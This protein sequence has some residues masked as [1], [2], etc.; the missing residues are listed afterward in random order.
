MRSK[1]L[2]IVSSLLAG[3]MIVMALAGCTV[4]DETPVEDDTSVQEE[5]PVVEDTP[6]TITFTDG[7]D[8]EVTVTKP[9]DTVVS[10]ISMISELMVALGEK[11]HIIA[12][13]R[14]TATSAFIFYDLLSLPDIT[15]SE[16]N[17][18]AVDYEAII[19]LDPDVFITGVVP[20][21]GF[22]DIV[23]ALE[24]EI[25][26]I[27]LSYDTPDEIV[28]SVELLGELFDCQEAA[29]EYIEFFQGTIDMIAE[30]T[31][32]IPEED[33]PVVYYEWLPYY[34][35][36]KDLY[37]YQNQIDLAGGV[38]AAADMA[39]TYGTIDPEWVIE[40]DPDII[41]SMT[42]D[43][44]YMGYDAVE[45]GY[46]VDDYS[47]MIAYRDSILNRSELSGVT[48]IKEGRVYV[49]HY[50]LSALSCIG[51]AYMAKWLHPDLFEDLDPQALH[52]EWLTRFM[53]ID[54]DLDEHGVFVYPQE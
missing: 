37:I 9:V 44:T 48:A 6:E 4:Q 36:N 47:S 19:E 11:D 49:F 28:A 52:Q 13:D 1:A 35:F 21:D 46:E 42:M 51:Y 10:G 25:P 41:L 8:H 30:R 20:Q 22:D 24:P 2:K 45:C 14:S 23:A 26:V 40:Q 18:Y 29:D 32:D 53:G 38:N 31:A 43:Y 5:T 27:A 16:D 39:T 3:L 15:T 34:T 50:N 17:H 33:K 12:I 7:F 54:Y